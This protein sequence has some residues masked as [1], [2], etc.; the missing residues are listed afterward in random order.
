M[1]R[2]VPSL[3]ADAEPQSHRQSE[4]ARRTRAFSFYDRRMRKLA[5]LGVSFASLLFVFARSPEERTITD[6]GSVISP[7]DANAAPVPIDD[8]FL[9]RSVTGAS[10]S[11]DGKEIVFGTNTTG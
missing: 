10:W 2:Q 11:P 1:S 4:N 8:L 7:R 5:V 3:R 6:P 9:S